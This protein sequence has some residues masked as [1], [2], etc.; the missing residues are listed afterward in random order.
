MSMLAK[1]PIVA[2]YFQD[3]VKCASGEIRWH[4]GGGIEP[5]KTSS[6]THGIA[7]QVIGTAGTGAG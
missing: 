5:M 4:C 1:I 7:V 6:V 2:V 3:S